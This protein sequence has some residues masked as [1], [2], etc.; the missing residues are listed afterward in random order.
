MTSRRIVGAVVVLGLAMAAMVHFRLGPSELV[1]RIVA[2]AAQAASDTRSLLSGRY[3]NRIAS[4]LRDE[5]AAIPAPAAAAEGD[6]QAELNRDLAAERKR[7]LEERAQVLQQ[8]A[9]QILS[10]D[11]DKMR[12]RVDK[13]ARDAGGTE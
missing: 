2:K 4:K 6:Y 3:A 1:D 11:A 5:A 12:A 10:G 7:M 13:A 8:Q 9:G